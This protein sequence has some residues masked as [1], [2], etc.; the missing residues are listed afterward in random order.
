MILVGGRIP[1][2]KNTYIFYVVVA[3]GVTEEST[4]P[5]PPLKIALNKLPLEDCPH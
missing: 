5:P 1:F 2:P 4:L 3:K